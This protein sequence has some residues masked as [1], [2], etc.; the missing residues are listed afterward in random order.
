MTEKQFEKY[1]IQQYRKLGFFACKMNLTTQPGFPDLYVA[2]DKLIWL[3]ELKVVNKE[4]DIPKCFQ[5][6]QIPFYKKY[7]KHG[8]DN[9]KIYV[10]IKELKKCKI[11][12]IKDILDEISKLKK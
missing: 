1:I 10:Y 6:S 4:S 8:T 3:I 11:Y 12:S 2:K 9:I 7:M 5:K